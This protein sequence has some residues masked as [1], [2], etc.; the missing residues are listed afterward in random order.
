MTLPDVNQDPN[1]ATQLNA[2]INGVET[3][4]LLAAAN[5]QATADAAAVKAQNLADLTSASSARTNLGLG[6]A[7]VLAVG[8]TAGTVA[9]GNDSRIVGA[10][11]DTRQILAGTGL[12]GGGT[13]AADRTLTVAY[14]TSSTTAAVGNDTRITGAVQNTRQVLAGT[15][16][17]GGGDLSADR[18]LTV[19]YGSTGTT[20]C[21]G[22]DSRLSD[23]RTP[24]ALSVTNASVS[25]SAAIALSKLATD[26]LARANHTG[27]QLASTVSD[28][29]TAVATTAALKANNLSDVTAA[30]AR[31]NLAVPSTSRLITAGTGLTGGG[32]LSADRT[33]TVAYGTSSTTAA[34]G[35]DS[36]LSDART[37]TDHDHSVASTQGG[38]LAV[39]RAKIT[40]ASTTFNATNN[41]NTT[42][43]FDAQTFSSASGPTW[44]SG[45][46]ITLPA[47]NADWK[48]T[49]KCVFQNAGTNGGMRIAQVLRVGDDLLI[50]EA[51][52]TGPG[53][54]ATDWVVV[55]AT[56]LYRGGASQQFYGRVKQVSGSTM[57]IAEFTV[58][59][60]LVSR[61]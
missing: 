38:F 14:G 12:T 61:T 57:T 54:S 6:G 58:A 47:I 1:W 42:F 13:L 44:S 19:A 31:T 35:N 26:P 32:D 36:R 43:N 33:L 55:N 5:A 53:G 2:H 16:L 48:V 51:N 56:E 52:G 41:T 46:N 10:V 49:V 18:T 23:T 27:T 3:A 8:T 34:V 9:A 11:Q 24:T 15:G 25:A 40:R 4:G 22:N 29:S 30:T 37:P 17:T 7:A 39:P 50:C 45:A 59:I 20:A 21:V 60:V 28:F